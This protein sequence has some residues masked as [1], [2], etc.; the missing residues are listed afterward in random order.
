MFGKKTIVV[1][2]VSLDSSW[3]RNDLFFVEPVLNRQAVDEFFGNCMAVVVIKGV[4]L[5]ELIGQVGK[6][7]LPVVEQEEVHCV[8]PHNYHKQD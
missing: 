4:D 5:I 1:Q 6:R 7:F 2:R 8:D 3:V